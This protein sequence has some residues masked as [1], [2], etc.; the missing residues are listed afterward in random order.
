[1][2]TK[3]SGLI[4]GFH[5]CDETVRDGIISGSISSLKAKNNP[6]DWLGH[7]L[8]FWENNSERALHFAQEQS[9][10]TN[11]SIKNPAV[12]GAILDLGYCLDLMDMGNI[13]LVKKTY[14]SLEEAFKLAGQKMPENTKPSK[15][16]DLLFRNLDCAVIN[17]LHVQQD[18]IKPFESVKG[19]FTEGGELYKNAGFHEK[20]HIQICVRNPN[21]IKGFFLPRKKIKHHLFP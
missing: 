7:G 10:R 20:N 19:I 11:S 21:C 8:Y 14:T 5:G 15:D 6:W 4:I 17:A 2:Y 18:T 9:E 1:M 16:G 13:E 12:L 3:R